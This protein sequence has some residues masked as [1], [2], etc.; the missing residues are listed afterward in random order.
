MVTYRQDPIF[1]K[2][3]F[4]K[5]G[6]VYAFKSWDGPNEEFQAALKMTYTS[7]ITNQTYYGWVFIN[8]EICDITQNYLY[9]AGC[10]NCEDNCENC[11]KFHHQNCHIGITNETLHEVIM[12]ILIGDFYS[13]K[14]V[15]DL[16]KYGKTIS[17]YDTFCDG[18]NDKNY[19]LGDYYTCV[20]MCN[21]FKCDFDLCMKCYENRVKVSYCNANVHPF[22]TLEKC[23]PD[24]KE[25]LN[26][27]NFNYIDPEYEEVEEFVNSTDFNLLNK[28]II[29]IEIFFN[30]RTLK[31]YY[32]KMEILEIGWNSIFTSSQILTVLKYHL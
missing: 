28:D 7:P 29:N 27:N 9:H 22:S 30:N 4:E 14:I 6:K 13:H 15:R 2:E 31:N 10:D 19:I 8:W 24:Y 18:C 3:V 1:F 23:S 17:L 12:A 20:E 32:L 21:E 11:R 26:I 5:V 25:D 16:K